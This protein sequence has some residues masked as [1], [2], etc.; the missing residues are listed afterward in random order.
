MKLLS[1]RLGVQEKRIFKVSINFMSIELFLLTYPVIYNLASSIEKVE[2][3][4][5]LLEAEES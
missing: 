4:L 3:E 2:K 1:E 5:S